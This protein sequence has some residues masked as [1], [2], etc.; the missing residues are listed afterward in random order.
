MHRTLKAETARP[1]R[2]SFRAQQRAFDTFRDEYN[3]VRPHEALGQSTPTSV[4][5]PS[6]RKFPSSL[7]DPEYP[8][9]FRTKR[10]D[11]HGA[12][13]F[14]GTQWYLGHCLCDEVVGLEELGTGCWKLYFGQ[15]ELAI[16]DLRATRRRGSMKYALPIR[17]DG[18]PTR[19]PSAP[20]ADHYPKVLPMSPV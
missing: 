19:R 15:L 16:L 8:Y 5:A 13:S 12:L 11:R 2:A 10:V 17:T 20:G 3:S 4:Y 1:P 14:M 18:Q 9:G 7:D 6:P